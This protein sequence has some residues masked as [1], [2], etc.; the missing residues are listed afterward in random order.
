MQ[1]RTRYF[2]AGGKAN[3]PFV[4]LALYFSDAASTFFWID[5]AIF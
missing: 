1:V 3:F 5:V 2:F 4:K